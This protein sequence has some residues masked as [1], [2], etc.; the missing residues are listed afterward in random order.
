MISLLFIFWGLWPQH[1]TNKY[2]DLP[3]HLLVLV[4]FPHFL[5]ISIIL[6]RFFGTI[7]SLW[8]I[9][10]WLLNSQSL[11]IYTKI[12]IYTNKNTNIYIYI[13]LFVH[14]PLH[15]PISHHHLLH[16]CYQVFV[17]S[18]FTYKMPGQDKPNLSHLKINLISVFPSELSPHSASYCSLSGSTCHM[19]RD[20]PLRTPIT[21]PA[22]Y[23][24]F[25]RD[26]TSSNNRWRQKKKEK[27]SN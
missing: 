26:F 18:S 8:D 1:S 24:E 19:K 20:E 12:D 22:A 16:H 27:Q 2:H 25:L 9:F 7:S 14:F 15:P 5:F 10:S 23:T 3:S 13:Y 21:P 17:V 4:F 6:G 11:Y